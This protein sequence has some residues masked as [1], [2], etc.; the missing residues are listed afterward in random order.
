MNMLLPNVL[1]EMKKKGHLET[2]L[3][4]NRMVNDGSFPFENIA[5]IFFMGV[6][7]FLSCKNTSRIRYSDKGKHFQRIGYY[8]ME[9]GLNL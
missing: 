6:C 2:W 4:L 5:F 9:N 1:N 3:N 8:Y 7:I